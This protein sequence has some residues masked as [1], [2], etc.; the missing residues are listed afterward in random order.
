MERSTFQARWL[1]LLLENWMGLDTSSGGFLDSALSCDVTDSI[2]VAHG[3]QK[4]HGLILIFCGA[5][6]KNNN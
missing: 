1:A 3:L 6:A 5:I 4:K 2:L